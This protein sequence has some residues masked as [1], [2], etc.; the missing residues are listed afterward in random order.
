MFETPG[1]SQNVTLEA[2]HKTQQI[3]T[4]QPRGSPFMP[5]QQFPGKNKAMVV[6]E[7]SFPSGTWYETELFCKEVETEFEELPLLSP[8]ET[9]HTLS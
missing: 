2:A 3:Q 5:Q 4:V 9:A 1:E 7:T 6:L 8:T